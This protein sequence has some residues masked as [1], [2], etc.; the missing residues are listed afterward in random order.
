LKIRFNPEE[1][2]VP[3]PGFRQAKTDPWTIWTYD[4]SPSARGTH[5][6]R[7][8]IADPAVRARKLDLGLYDRIVDLS[9]I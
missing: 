5:W 7:M 1:Q 8:A 4:W 2:F 6:I 3:V 9:E